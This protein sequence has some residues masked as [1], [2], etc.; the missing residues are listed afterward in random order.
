MLESQK[1]KKKRWLFEQRDFKRWPVD[2]QAEQE[3]VEQEED[4]RSLTVTDNQYLKLC[5]V[6]INFCYSFSLNSILEHYS[7]ISG[8]CNLISCYLS[9]QC[10]VILCF[11]VSVPFFPFIPRPLLISAFPFLPPFL[12]LFLPFS[13]SWECVLIPCFHQAPTYFCV[14]VC[15]LFLRLSFSFPFRSNQEPLGADFRDT[16]QPAHVS[17]LFMG[18]VM[19]SLEPLQMVVLHVCCHRSVAKLLP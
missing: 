15:F 18:C 14:Y 12:I 6:C 8:F 4:S 10:S 2:L 9:L 16:Y 7:W 19:F 3:E 17:F 5:C 13:L 11:L 1:K